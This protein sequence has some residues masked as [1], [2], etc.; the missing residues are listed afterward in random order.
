M[1]DIVL[2]WADGQP[3]SR[4]FGDVYFSRDG[5]LAETR[6][7]FLDGNRLSARFAA[8]P[9]HAVFTIGETG[10]GTGLNFLAA[11]QL[12]ETTAP[13]RCRLHFVSTEIDP[14]SATELASALALWP[15]LRPWA[16][17]LL[18]QYGALPPAWHRF[19]FRGGRI[20]LTLLVGDARETLPRLDARV[21][22]WFLDGFSPARNPELWSDALFRA[23]SQASRDGTTVA[24][25]SSAGAVRRGLEAAGFRMDK[26]AGFGRKREMLRGTFVSTARGGSVAPWLRRPAPLASRPR[27]AIVIGA[28]LAGTA[29]AASL[30]RRGVDVTLVEREDHVAAGASGNPQGMLY[31][32]PSAHGTVLTQLL[33]GG[34][35]FT[36][37][38]LAAHLPDDATAWSR[39]G[40]LALAHDAEEAL[41]QQALAA[42][43]WPT[44]FS[45]VVDRA[46]AGAL[47]GVPLPTGGLFYDGGWVHPPALCAAL[48]RIA[49]TC[50]PRT[51]RWR[52][53]A[54]TVSGMCAPRTARRCAPIWSSS[55]RPVTR[56]RWARRRR[57]H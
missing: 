33:L 38:E 14:L 44:G 26:I 32:N 12:F 49:S 34:L 10:F 8:L 42:L 31:I 48:A 21:D 24:T 57:C 29:A 41:R 43:G 35:G 55:R 30:A 18:A 47:A 20:V 37:R 16:Q 1:S 3:V 51:A 45:R 22:A 2:D 36:L 17:P 52:W 9:E 46:E 40:V 13:A 50:D 25:Y 28:G 15:E 56:G 6:H 27:T 39:C 5:G 23:M 11:W 54:T 19:Q 4:R 53:S 7:V